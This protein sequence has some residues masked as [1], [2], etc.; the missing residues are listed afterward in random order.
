[1]KG[2]FRLAN[3]DTQDVKKCALRGPIDRWSG[4][5]QPHQT[6]NTHE[7]ENIRNEKHHEATLPA[8]GNSTSP[9]GENGRAVVG[10]TR[11]GN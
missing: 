2:K 1:M 7:P 6:P 8:K 10:V 4:D 11:N 3:Y 5:H 9:I